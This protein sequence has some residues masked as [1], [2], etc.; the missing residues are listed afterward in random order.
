MPARLQ[1]MMMQLQAYDFELKFRLGKEMTLHD[2]LS[3]YHPK[4]RPDI[5]LD[6]AIHHTQLT[7]QQKTTFQDTI[8]TDPELQALSQMIIDGWPEDASDVLKNLKRY[9]SHASTMT[10]ED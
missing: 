10:V 4:L 2:A 7:T 9:F 5:P 1:R 8:A 3:R 6:I